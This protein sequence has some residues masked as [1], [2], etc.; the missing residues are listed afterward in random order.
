L[1]N[2]ALGLTSVVVSHDVAEVTSIADYIYIIADGKVIGQGTPSE[3][4]HHTSERVRQ[5]LEGLPD[6]PVPFH[7][8]APD[9]HFDLLETEQ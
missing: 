9:Y 1:L 7:F 8:P 3:I 6:G 2:D 5:F 4:R